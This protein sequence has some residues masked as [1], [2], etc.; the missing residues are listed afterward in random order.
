MFLESQYQ[1]WWRPFWYFSYPKIV[2]CILPLTLF[3][4]VMQK[5][6]LCHMRTIKVQISLM[7]SLISTFA[8]RSLDSIMPQANNI[9]IWVEFCMLSSYAGLSKHSQKLSKLHKL[10]LW[11]CLTQDD[12]WTNLSYL[13]SYKLGQHWHVTRCREEIVDAEMPWKAE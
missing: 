3:G 2:H 1:P 9:D 7:R 12:S 4:P 11:L 10:L 8:V 5:R 6:V 13:L